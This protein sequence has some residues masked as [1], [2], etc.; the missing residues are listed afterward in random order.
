MNDI[1]DEINRKCDEV[2]R[3]MADNI[4][5][6]FAKLRCDMR[7]GLEREAAARRRTIETVVLGVL[8]FVITSALLRYG[9]FG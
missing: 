8:C 2:K 5:R 4:E 3:R 1:R 7:E 6:E 9:V